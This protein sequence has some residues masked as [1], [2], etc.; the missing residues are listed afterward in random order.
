MVRSY[1]LIPKI[2]QL[3]DYLHFVILAK[4]GI[5]FTKL[6]SMCEV[7]SFA[8]LLQDGEENRRVECSFPNF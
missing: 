6:I 7:H 1:Q 4:K 2:L 5:F 3:F 8:I